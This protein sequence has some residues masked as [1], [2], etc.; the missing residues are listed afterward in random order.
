MSDS[1]RL[2]RQRQIAWQ[3]WHPYLEE[4]RFYQFDRWLAREFKQQA[5]FGKRDRTLYREWLYA[6]L[7]H[8]LLAACLMEGG[9]PERA[10]AQ[11]TERRL[12]AAGLAAWWR[13]L[14][15][16]LFFALVEARHQ[17]EPG[18]QV[19]PDPMHLPR[20]LAESLHALAAQA[21]AG[22]L[23]ALL[24][25]QGIPWD[26]LAPIEARAQ[27]SGW[28]SDQLLA[29]LRM[30][31]RR[32]P[33]WVRLN[34]PEREAECLAELGERVIG[35]HGQ[36]LALSVQGSLN[37]L[38]CFQEGW[39][40]IQDLASQQ[41]GARVDC[42]PGDLVWDACAGGGG[43]TLQLAAR[44]QGQGLI[45]ASDIRTDKL[46]EV[47]RRHSLAGFGDLRVT[48]WDGNGLPA[49][50]AEVRGRHGFDWVL[51]DAPCSSSGTWRRNPEVRFRELGRS[52]DELTALQRRLLLQAAAAVR[53]GGRLVYGTCSFR[54]EENEAVVASLLAQ[55]GW[56]LE[57]QGLLGCPEQDAD[58]MFQAVIRR[59][60]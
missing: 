3:L 8:G 13:R 43:K 55:E 47:Q 12:D 11:W 17:L 14:N 51:V 7:R 25:W 20:E 44:L 37:G 23:P 6:A 57:S 34:R 19:L 60:G 48:R 58:T 38:R 59:R 31:N 42:R 10:L 52:L 2:S 1:T 36:A 41:I 22:S 33:V 28:G 56:Q 45:L 24:L 5:R 53:P 39:L 27:T 9:S 30:Q 26:Y 40:E 54:V 32:P 15:P 50:P 49:L 35:R 29:W 46:K 4:G 18:P 16:E 21:Q